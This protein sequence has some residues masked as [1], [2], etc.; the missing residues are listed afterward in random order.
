MHLRGSC[1]AGQ[2]GEDDGLDSLSYRE[3]K[4]IARREGLP[5]NKSAAEL[6][7]RIRASRS[8]TGQVRLDFI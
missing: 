8:Q 4:K 6:R 1:F 5:M 7:D 2:G 3:L